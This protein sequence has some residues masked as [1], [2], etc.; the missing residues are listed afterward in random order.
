VNPVS[1]LTPGILRRIFEPLPQ[2]ESGGSHSWTPDP[3]PEA[4]AGASELPSA[5]PPDV[6]GAAQTPV[7]ASTAP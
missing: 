7:A 3:A 2:R 1:A 6:A 4:S 5:I